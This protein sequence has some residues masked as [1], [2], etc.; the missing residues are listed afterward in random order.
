MAESD[1]WPGVND[2]DVSSFCAEKS[3]Y[4]LAQP[5]L[6]DEHRGASMMPNEL[7][8]YDLLPSFAHAR[9]LH[10]KYVGNKSEVISL[11]RALDALL[12]LLVVDRAKDELPAE[13]LIHRVS[14]ISTNER[15]WT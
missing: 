6:D 11:C 13:F 15:T 9:T 14:D 1:S 10:F 4:K 7:V 3:K 5:V 12:H 2:D 8:R